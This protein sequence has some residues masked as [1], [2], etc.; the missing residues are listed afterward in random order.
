MI[1]TLLF[2]ALLSAADPG[3][4]AP[5]V[6]DRRASACAASLEVVRSIA[7]PKKDPVIFS[8]WIGQGSESINPD[9]KYGWNP[10]DFGRENSV[11][12]PPRE[13][14]VQ[15][16]AEPDLS[17]IE[18]CAVIRRF[19]TDNHI[20]FGEAAVNDAIKRHDPDVLIA[21]VSLARL[22]AE[23]RRALISEG[24]SGAEGGGGG[25]LYSMVIDKTGRWQKTHT[26]PTWIS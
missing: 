19:L 15:M 6:D 13:A 4:G 16:S 7:L 21:S 1:A 22:D 18:M 24:N 23:G 11:S 10:T 9:A 26:A 14:L 12:V 2:G 25:W 20:E 5:V 8:S 17:A 3:T